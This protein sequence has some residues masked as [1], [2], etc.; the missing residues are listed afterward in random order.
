LTRCL[1]LSDE[2]AAAMVEWFS[3]SIR[4][5]E[6]A[7]DRLE[8]RSPETPLTPESACELL[9]ETPRGQDLV[10]L[11]LKAVSKRFQV[12]AEDLRG[13]KRDKA[14]TDPRQVSMYLAH[15]LT[16]RPPE[17]IGAYFGGRK[18][19]SVRRAHR[20]VSA[21]AASDA[22]FR[23]LLDELANQVKNAVSE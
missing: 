1:N 2:V 17:E 15:T 6:Q 3:H 8:A 22:G 13:F 23:V 18:D 5:L 4:E 10:P 14:V 21:R 19:V 11:I 20:L 9:R 12:G 16:D 7:L